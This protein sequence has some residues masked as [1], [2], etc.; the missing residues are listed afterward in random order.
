VDFDELINWEKNGCT[1][2]VLEIMCCIL[3][4]LLFAS[5]VELCLTVI[6]LRGSILNDTPRSGIPY[7]M[8][9][10]LCMKTFLTFN[11]SHSSKSP[12]TPEL[13]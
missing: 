11:K 13:I 5:V 9:I 8:Y 4:L 7:L 12:S 6:S 3:V 1:A 10:R 2:R